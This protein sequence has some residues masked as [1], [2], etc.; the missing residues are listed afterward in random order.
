MK[1]TAINAYRKNLALLKPYT[2][3]RHTVSDIENIFLEISLENG[4]MGIGAASPAEEVVGETY[5]QTFQNCRSDFF[6]HFVGRDIR[7]FRQLIDEATAHF[8]NLPGTQAAFDIA[9][10]DA[11]CQYLGVPIVEFYG[12]KIRSMPT[13]VTIGIMSLEET[14]FEAEQFKQLGFRVL[15]VKTGLDPELDIE[16]VLKLQERYKKHFTIR[17]DANQGY[18]LDDL[19]TFLT[20]TKTAEIELI[21]QLKKLRCLKRRQH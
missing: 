18:S 6:Q 16:R 14:L 15:K 8:P 19:N 17:V 1:I 11:F 2:I 10:H 5:D 7:H 9:A 13:S 12:Q 20:A 3:A 21:E 4:K